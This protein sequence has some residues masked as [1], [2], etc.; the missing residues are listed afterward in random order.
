MIN[1]AGKA[2]KIIIIP[3]VEL[4]NE[5]WNSLPPIL[6]RNFIAYGL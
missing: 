5:K 2:V 6:S 3:L 4:T 1:A